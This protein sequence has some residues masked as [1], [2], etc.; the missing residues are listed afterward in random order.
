MLWFV[1]GLA[2]LV[3][4]VVV[5]RAFSSASPA[6]LAAIFKW[7]ALAIASAAAIVLLVRGNGGWAMLAFSAAAALLAS[8]RWP[9]GSARSTT[10]TSDIETEWLRMSLDHDSGDTAGT[11]LRGR[12]AGSTLAELGPEALFDLLGELRI[13]DPQSALL[14]EAYLKRVHPDLDGDAPG[15]QG[16]AETSRGQ[17][18]REE[19]LEVLG[20][21][22]DAGADEIREAHRRLMQQVHPDKGGSDYLAAQINRAR[23]VLLKG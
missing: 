16:A 23:D 7:I 21:D 19:A 14:L 1:G 18:S 3:F 15:G 9:G 6:R 20:L 5:L 11:V 2:L 13:H 12:Y 17:M 4:A 10:R 8:L 22:E